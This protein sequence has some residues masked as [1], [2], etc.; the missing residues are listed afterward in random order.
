[1]LEP[2]EVTDMRLVA[3]ASIVVYRDPV[4]GKLYLDPNLPDHPL[5][6]LGDIKGDTGAPGAAGSNGTDGS[7]GAKGDKGEP[8]VIDPQILQAG[9]AIV[10]SAQDAAI[11]ANNA[12]AYATDQANLA[13]MNASTA[14]L[15]A[16]TAAQQASKAYILAGATLNVPRAG[17]VNGL[18]IQKVDS[19]SELLGRV[20]VFRGLLKLVSAVAGNVSMQINIGGLIFTFGGI[21]VVSGTQF[22]NYETTVHVVAANVGFAVERRSFAGAGGTANVV[23]ST[24]NGQSGAL[25]SKTALIQFKSQVTVQVT[26]L[27]ALMQIL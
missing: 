18:E 26:T 4:T 14:T 21:S 25:V 12:A 6:K 24:S 7:P 15:A 17:V 22:F 1:M 5:F 11:S 16:N 13:V 3:K 8:G 23:Q 2:V 9:Q 20:V 19:V 27:L 10:Q